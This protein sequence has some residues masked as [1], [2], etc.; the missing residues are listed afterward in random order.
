MSKLSYKRVAVAL[1]GLALPLTMVAS[2]AA[3][4]PTPTEVGTVAQA[5]LGVA[6]IRDCTGAVKNGVED[7][8]QG[9][10]N[11]ELASQGISFTVDISEQ[12]SLA[13]TAAATSINPLPP[14]AATGTVILP[15]GVSAP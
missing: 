15:P 12:P 13:E 10:V 1:V 7:V 4:A 8:V 3:Q 14:V 2:A 5:C 11:S 9:S 6:T